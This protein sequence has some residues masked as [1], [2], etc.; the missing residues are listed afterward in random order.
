MIEIVRINDLL[1]YSLDGITNILFEGR[2]YGRI[3]IFGE[4]GEFF[5]CLEERQVIKVED[6]HV[7]AE[8]RILTEIRPNVFKLGYLEN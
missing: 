8:Y 1:N 5:Y 2:F 4:Q 6:G 3:T 7:V